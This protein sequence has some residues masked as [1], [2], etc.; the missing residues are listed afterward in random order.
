MFALLPTLP[1]LQHGADII[2][3]S[4]YWGNEHGVFPDEMML[5]IARHLS[6]LPHVSAIIGHHPKLVQGH[7]YFGETLVIFSPGV[8]LS[9]DND[10]GFCWRRVST[11]TFSNQYCLML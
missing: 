1:S 5:Y 6:N 11:D 3:V 10:K 4:V 8:F 9:P 2:I 7:A